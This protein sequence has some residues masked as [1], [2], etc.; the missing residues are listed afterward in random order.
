MREFMH[1]VNV[2][3]QKMPRGLA[4]FTKVFLIFAA[5]FPV[6][7]L[8]LTLL[9]LLDHGHYIHYTMNG[10]EVTYDE[11]ARR[12]GFVWFVLVGFFC[13]VTAYGLLHASRWS[14]PLVVLPVATS[15]VFAVWVVIQH[16]RPLSPAPFF[17]SFFTLALVIWYLYFRQTVRDYFAGTHEL[18]D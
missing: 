17:I 10:T 11:F 6:L 15:P 8:L 1:F 9:P 13:G 2:R 7:T 3:L 5:I 14:R 12:S 18:E 4:V 16:H